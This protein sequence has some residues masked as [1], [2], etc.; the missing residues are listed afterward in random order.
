MKSN[1]SLP[2]FL[3]L[4]CSIHV[5]SAQKKVKVK[6]EQ[7]KAICD[8]TPLN[9][10]IRLAVTRFDISTRGSLKSK[11]TGNENYNT[12]W[13]F[14][15]S[16]SQ[17]NPEAGMIEFGGNMATMLQ[18]ALQQTNCF[19]VLVN[20]DNK[21]DL[22]KEIRFGESESADKKTAIKK[23]NMK[24]AQVVVT[25]EIT[26]FNNQTSGKTFGPL[27]LSKQIVR[28]GFIVTITNPE[29]REVFE[30]RSFNVEGK[31]S[32]KVSI[33]VGLPTILGNQRVDF[34]GGNKY[35]PA[36]ANA[37][38]QGL[39]QAAEWLSSQK[40]IMIVPEIGTSKRTGNTNIV[41]SISN[42][43]YNKFR[44]FKEVVKNNPGVKKM[45]SSFDSQIATLTLEYNGST[46]KLLD[47]IMSGNLSSLL[48]VI[49]QKEGVIHLLFK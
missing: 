36:V 48:T 27:K 35:T 34:S 41:I 39:I 10:R 3:L 37:L 6:E 21:E 40:D 24:S 2:A 45:E 18:T 11:A 33:G 20:L 13:Y 31:S 16:N 25:G 44:D 38:E 43:D 14:N 7:V 28:L 23:G 19:N 26:E 1:L 17:T 4:I 15:N 32:D 9:E 22:D 30:S 29:T 47:E 42:A 46:S 8:V 5:A 12:N 49:T